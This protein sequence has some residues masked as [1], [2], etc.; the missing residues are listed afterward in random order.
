LLA[1]IWGF[2][3]WMAGAL[4]DLRGADSGEET[5]AGSEPGGTIPMTNGGGAP[6]PVVDAVADEGSPVEDEGGVVEDEGGE[7]GVVVGEGVVIGEV[8][9]GPKIGPRIW[10]T[11]GA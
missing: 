1:F 3:T 11:P 6:P 9:V 5:T 10:S 4:L 2:S 7:G 8:G